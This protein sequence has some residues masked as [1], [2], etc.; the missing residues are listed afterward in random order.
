MGA[1]ITI[2]LSIVL[3]CLSV[4]SVFAG[5]AGPA[6]S[7]AK[8][9]G[10]AK[11]MV[12]FSGRDEIIAKA[13][14]EGKL[15]LLVNMDVPTLKA[16]AKVFTQKYPFIDVHAR[17]ITG[18]AMIQRNVLEIK[19]GQAT[20]EWDVAYTSRDFYSEYLP[21]LWKVD[22]LRMAEQGVLQIP[23]PMIDP[24]NRNIAAFYSRLIV[25][26]YNKNLVP[27]DQVPKAWEDFV[28]PE[29][30]GKKFAVDI[31]PR[32]LACMVPA[33]GLEKTLDFA[34]KLAAQQPIWV[35][36][37]TRTVT[38]MIAGEIPMMIGTMFHSVKRA[39]IKD[40]AG[41][42][43]YVTLEPAPVYFHSEQAV[44][45][46]AQNPHAALLWLEWMASA[47]SQKLADEH[48]PVGSSRYFRG[49]A[50]EQE[51][52]G[53]KLSLVTWE[54]HHN[55]ESWMTKVFEAYGFPKAERN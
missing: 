11:G 31:G 23:T 24:Q 30:K 46:G 25:S 27:A 9:E 41:V 45:A 38:G 49:G 35:Q 47:E 5:E 40:R 48:E 53:K 36:G 44:L 7:K 20:R 3:G 42:L 2:T 15:R 10:E 51:L 26:A 12:S 16:A 37:V 32:W 54:N 14:K 18:S 29:F 22:L 39:Q 34:R 43:Q 28:K 13:K 50:V 17:E 21:Y 8:Q 33:W 4:S 52:K 1:M 19:S 6:A 55:I